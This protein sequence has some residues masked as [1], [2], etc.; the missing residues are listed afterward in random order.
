MVTIQ[1]PVKMG[2]NSVLLRFSSDLPTPTF[3]IYVDGNLIAQTTK[4]EYLLAINYDENYMIE[5]L[6]DP[7]EQ[8]TQ[9]FPGK[10]RLGWFPVEGTDYY[11]I[12]EYIDSQWVPKKKMKE[13]G[14][15]LEW[16]SR[17][18]EDGQTHNFRIVP[19]GADGNDGEPR[20]FAVLIV[21]HPDVPDVG[22]QYAGGNVTISEN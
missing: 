9:I 5:I 8:P 2:Q 17:F 11:R 19:V 6:D 3:Y 21:R 16:E 1:P 7:N 13:N 14:G 12:D 15:Y 20:A 4:T 10:I 22:Y 18:L